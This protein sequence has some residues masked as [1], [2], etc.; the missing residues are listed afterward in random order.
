MLQSVFD[1]TGFNDAS[2]LY[3]ASNIAWPV[4]MLL[5]A[6][7]RCDRAVYRGAEGLATVRPALLW[8]GLACRHRP[9]AYLGRRR[10]AT[11]VPHPYGVGLGSARP[12]GLPGG[13]GIKARCRFRPLDKTLQESIRLN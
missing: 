6:H 4:S 13:T 9:R 8:S 5:T 12:H 3:M 7:H 10:Y 2:V 1:P 11:L